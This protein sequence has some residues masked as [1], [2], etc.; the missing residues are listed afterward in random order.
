MPHNVTYRAKLRPGLKDLAGHPVDLKNWGAEFAYDK[1]TL[2]TLR[3]L[4]VFHKEEDA[5]SRET[6]DESN[7]AVDEKSNEPQDLT[8]QSQQADDGEIEE[9]DPSWELVA[10]P[11]VELEFSRDILPQDVQKAVYFQDK[12]THEHFPVEVRLDS[13]QSAGPQG[14]MI[15]EPI[16]P[17]PPGRPFLLVIDPL[18]EPKKTGITAAFARCPGGYDLSSK[19]PPHFRTKPAPDWSVHSHN[20]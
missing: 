14:W 20:N 16:D 8:D 10:R 7:P 6:N 11:Q 17:L 5:S 9:R 19:N 3:F 4:N 15:I 1:F 13:H 18:K 12:E 2:R